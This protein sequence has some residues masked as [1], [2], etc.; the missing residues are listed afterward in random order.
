[1]VGKGTGPISVPVLNH[2]LIKTKIYMNRA[3]QTTD[4]LVWSKN[5]NVS[6]PKM[7]RQVQKPEQ[8]NQTP[9]N[10]PMYQKSPRGAPSVVPHVNLNKPLRNYYDSLPVD[11]PPPNTSR[12]TQH[13]I[14][15]TATTQPTLL[16]TNQNPERHA[17][18]RD[19]ED[20]EDIR[21][22]SNDKPTPMER[23]K[24]FQTPV[25]TPFKNLPDRKP[26]VSI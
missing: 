8:N 12:P 5:K 13:P 16:P 10:L 23:S 7:W 22:G 26:R 14:T 15:N 3:R 9:Q 11:I 19:E 17:L 18:E 25:K 20:E 6:K 24:D 1:V 2:P 4:T 21:L